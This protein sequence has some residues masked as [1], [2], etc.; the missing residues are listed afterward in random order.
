MNDKLTNTRTFFQTEVVYKD[1]TDFLGNFSVYSDAERYALNPDNHDFPY[2][3]ATKIK[4][5]EIEA[6]TYTVEKIIRTIDLL[7][8]KPDIVILHN[9]TVRP[10]HNGPYLVGLATNHPKWPNVVKK[11]MST[12]HITGKKR[13]LVVTKSGTKYDLQT[14]NVFEEAAKSVL[15]A[16]LPEL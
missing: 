6:K 11:E 10:H 12:G 15:M 2:S 9:W 3:E 13:G 7:A 5:T 14:D 16:C 8:P 1:K 4:I